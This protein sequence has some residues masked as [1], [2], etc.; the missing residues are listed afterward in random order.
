MGIG[1]VLLGI[2][3]W[4]VSTRGGPKNRD[5]T[6][7]FVGISNH[8]FRYPSNHTELH[9]WFWLTNGARPSLHWFTSVSRRIG[10]EWV[11]EGAVGPW[12]HQRVPAP[13]KDPVLDPAH[14][15]QLRSFKVLD[16]K[17]PLRIVVLVQER[18][19]GL[20]GI[21]E[22]LQQFNYDHIKKRSWWVANGRRYT[23]TNEF[24]PER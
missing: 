21:K 13:T 22:R 8:G 23:V 5:V 18:S 9:V 12:M 19:G 17:T 10:D 16:A 6:L 7:K 20:A 2:A 11:D 24:W 1:G 15:A 3:L 4:F 14:Q